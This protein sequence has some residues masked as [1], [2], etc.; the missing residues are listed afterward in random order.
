M[1]SL[2]NI[3]TW[4]E[5]LILLLLELTLSGDNIVFLVTS[6]SKL[7]VHQQIPARRIGLIVAM[8]SRLVFLGLIF[9]AATLNKPFLLTFSIHDIILI[10]GGGFLVINS[11]MEFKDMRDSTLKKTHGQYAKFGMVIIQILF[12]DVVFSIDSVFTAIGVS[13]H[14]WVMATAII[15]ATLFMLIASNCLSGWVEKHPIFKILALCFLILI[16][17]ILVIRGFG[18]EV[19]STYIYIPFI[20]AIFTQFIIHWTKT[21][22]HD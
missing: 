14:Y 11:L 20:Y 21:T 22:S 18:L 9:S 12:I 7:P 15:I 13:Q 6:T 1:E 19:S 4:L 10:V 17:L 8:V 2:L 5:L 16:G 3:H